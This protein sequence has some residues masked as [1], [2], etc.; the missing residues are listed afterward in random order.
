[1]IGWL[2]IPDT[3]IDEPIL[4]GENNDTYLRTDLY[5]KA[6]TAGNLF[7]DEINSRNF[8]DDNTIIYGHNMKNGSRFHD[9]RYFVEKDYFN[10]HQNI[11]IYLPDGSINIYQGVASAVIDSR[12]DLYQ[13][14]IDYQKYMNQVKSEASVYQNVSEKQVNMIMLST[15]YTGTENRY[16]VY[17]QL[18]ENYKR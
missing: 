1:M 2:Y 16:V 8:S 15:C 10:E 9:L 5:M 6:N 3:K 18:K 12:S 4:K 14:G 17:G 13:K 7:I 11:Y